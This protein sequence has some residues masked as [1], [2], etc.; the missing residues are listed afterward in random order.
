MK[1]Y[2]ISF[3]QQEISDDELVAFLETK[4]EVLNLMRLIPH[5]VLIASDRNASTVTRLIDKQFPQAFFIVAEYVPYNSDGSLPEESWNFL[6]KPKQAR[7]TKKS[8][9]KK[10]RSTGA[11]VISH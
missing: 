4:R 2:I 6:N 11:K 3:Y 1:A 9:N 8:A 10:K 5:T 7:R